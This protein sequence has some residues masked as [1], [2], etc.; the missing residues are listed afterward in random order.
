MTEIRK[1]TDPC[2]CCW[3]CRYFIRPLPIAGMLD[4]P[5]TDVCTVDRY[6]NQYLQPDQWH[7]GDK[8]VLPDDYCERFEIDPPPKT[9]DA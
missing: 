9:T 1:S 2:R 8:D 6:P 5:V 3:H 7:Q 4:G